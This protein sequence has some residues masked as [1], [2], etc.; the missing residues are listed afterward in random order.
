MMFL[1][2]AHSDNVDFVVKR[3]IFLGMN[4]L[5]S[6]AGR[7]MQD[8]YNNGEIKLPSPSSSFT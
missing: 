4:T 3:S 8:L 1:N 5:T 2:V 7:F 6:H